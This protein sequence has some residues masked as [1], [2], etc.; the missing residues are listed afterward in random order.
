MKRGPAPSRNEVMENR[1]TRM[2]GIPA[3]L[4]NRCQNSPTGQRVSRFGHGHVGCCSNAAMKLAALVAV[5][6][7][8]TVAHA[9]ALRVATAEGGEPAIAPP[10]MTPVIVVE[11]E[12]PLVDAPPAK[13][14][15]Q[16]Q[17]GI[18]AS[19]RHFFSGTAL[20]VPQGTVEIA[21]KTAIVV[22]GVSIAAG[23]TS[24][25]EIWA[26]VYTVIEDEGGVYGAGLKQVLGRGDSWQLAATAS[27]RG[28]GDG[29]DDEKIGSI[30]GIFSACTE[31]CN[32]MASAGIQVLF[33]DGE[34][35]SLPVFTGGV[36][37]GSA[38][39]RLVGEL[40]L[41]SENGESAG[42]GYFGVRFGSKK[43]AADLGLIRVIEDSSDDIPVWPLL[44]VAG[45]M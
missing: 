42:I 5:L 32:A 4:S 19:Q 24:T 8:P 27:V 40:L 34:D 1:E 9:D 33:A 17:S 29:F 26:D 16:Q 38:T 41:A 35:E 2:S 39:T 43:L 18:V 37:F 45:R 13:T 25:T 23:L 11:P 7:I 14:T 21:G 20:T 28:G 3:F 6:A 12:S 30:G 15:M 44:S 36:S 22:N 10:G 31:R